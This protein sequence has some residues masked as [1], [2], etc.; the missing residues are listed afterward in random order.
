MVQVRLLLPGNQTVLADTASKSELYLTNVFATEPATCIVKKVKAKK[1]D[2][3]WG[4]QS[5]T[6][7]TRTVAE[8]E[9]RFVAETDPYKREYFWRFLYLP[10][11]G[12]FA[13][14]PKDMGLGVIKD[15]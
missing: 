8:F 9:Q 11:Q 3:P 13:A 1:L 12:M 5:R 15:A 2:L 4:H 6:S 14:A 10:E 7:S